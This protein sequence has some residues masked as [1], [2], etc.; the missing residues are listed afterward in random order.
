MSPRF[1]TLAPDCGFPGVRKMHERAVLSRRA[2][3]QAAFGAGAGIALLRGAGAAGPPA[4]PEPSAGPPPVSPA[5]HRARLE[6]LQG[7]LQEQKVP[8]YLAESG[9][10]LEYFTGV[11]WWRSERTTAALIPAHGTPIVVTPF[12]EEPSI[13]ETLKVSADVRTWQEDQDPFALLADALRG[14]GGGV[15]AVEPTTRYFIVERV[16]R[17]AGAS[18]ALAQG[19]ALTRSC[20]SVKSAAE[21]ALLQAANAVTI[22]ALRRLHAEVRIGMDASQILARQVELTNSLGGTHEF[23]LVLVN[24]ASAKPHG[25]LEPQR[26]REGSV[27]LVDTGCSVH[28]YQSDISR[29]WVIGA[30]SSRQREL[31]ETVR[32][33]QQLALETARVGVPCGAVDRA[34]RTYYEGLGWRKD[35]ALPGLSHRTGHGIGMEVH[36][37]PYLVRNDATPLQPGMCFSD[38]PGLYIPGEFG[39]RLEDCWYMTSGGP[40]TF[41]PLAASIEQPI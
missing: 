34:V 13:R 14:A 36:E 31:W 5:E 35:Y 12:F 17:A 11:R 28:G 8:A 24:E 20:R 39:V 7:L 21:L 3:L 30:P 10:S 6:K 9:P 40:K 15:L 18:A 1:D 37:S 32:H 2:W 26:V 41:T 27:V 19:E 38:E 22:E 23:T 25:S 16:T 29:T 4:A 33:G